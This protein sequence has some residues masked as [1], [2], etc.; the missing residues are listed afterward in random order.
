MRRHIRRVMATAGTVAGATLLAVG[1]AGPGAA[2][3]AT[4]SAHSQAPVIY[5][6]NQAGYL[7]AGGRWFRYIGATVVVPPVPA[8]TGNAGYAELVLGGTG[9][10]P[11]SLGVKAGGGAA[12]VGWNS[13]GG[14][15]GMGG[16]TMTGI[17][18]NVGDV[19]ALSI[20]YDR[21]GH[22]FFT[23]T[24]YTMG[25]SQTVSV[26]SPPDVV[27]TAAEA[28]GVVSN[29]TVSAPTASIRLWSFTGGHVTTYSGTRGT[30]S[31]PWTTT[32]VVNTTTG[33]AGGQ[34]VTSP[35]P[36]W[37]S[38]QNFGVWLRPTA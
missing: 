36:L 1:L 38:G 29:A 26:P 4:S 35:G 24:D 20:Y 6:S 2:S 12:S 25:V 8:K 34:L 15:F 11:A 3:A 16:G 30:L 19:L 22:D 33:T 37:S 27:Y 14:L 7:V 28:A 5:T 13:V 17:S 10:T 23:A 9:V 18:P 32:T 21:A 31:G